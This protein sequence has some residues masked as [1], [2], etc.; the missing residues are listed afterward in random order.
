M[1][2]AKREAMIMDKCG[3]SSAH[4]GT[5]TK[6]QYEKFRS[7]VF[8]KSWGLSTQEKEDIFHDLCEA[9]A[10]AVAR[11]STDSFEQALGSQV[12]WYTGK[13]CAARRTLINI[14]KSEA[15]EVLV[16]RSAHKTTPDRVSAATK[17][18]ADLPE[19]TCK[20]HRFFEREPIAFEDVLSSMTASTTQS[21]IERLMSALRARVPERLMRVGVA[22]YAGKSNAQI[23]REFG[24]PCGT[25][26]YQFEQFM[27][28][29]KDVIASLGLVSFTDLESKA[30]QLAA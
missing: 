26:Q 25:V 24:I 5:L 14:E 16:F 15:P 3:K 30:L 9:A 17:H 13:K 10:R 27:I 4:A 12:H 23:S 29:S 22:R 7:I 20:T 19:L 6:Q 2:S 28:R 18:D 11:G 21:N 1:G 8:G